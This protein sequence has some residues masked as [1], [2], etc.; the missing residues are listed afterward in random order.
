MILRISILLALTLFFFD[1]GRKR[2]NPI[3]IPSPTPSP[4]AMPSPSVQPSPL[5]P[6]AWATPYPVPAIDP[7]SYI[8]APPLTGKTV[9]V[10]QDAD[11]DYSAEIQAAEDDPTVSTVIIGPGSLKRSV[12][13]R[14]HTRIDLPKDTALACD[15]TE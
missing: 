3:P 10:R 11:E 6:I 13:L 1:C 8:P 4:V 12:I 9:A 5:V 2:T 14:K 15:I 7:D